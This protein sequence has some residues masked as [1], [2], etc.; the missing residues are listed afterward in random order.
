MAREAETAAPRA[1]L[2]AGVVVV[3]H[4]PT[5]VAAPHLIMVILE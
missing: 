1:T 5:S 3:K 4:F 2:A